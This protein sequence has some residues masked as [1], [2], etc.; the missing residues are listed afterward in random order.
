MID[1]RYIV[2]PVLLADLQAPCQPDTLFITSGDTTYAYTVV[3]D[4][5][6]PSEQY[7]VIGRYTFDPERVAVSMD[8]KRGK[9]SGVYRAWYPNGSPLI[10]AVYGWGTLHGDWTEYDEFGRVAVKGQYRDGLREGTWAFRSEDIV[11]HYD[12]GLKHGKWKYYQNGQLIRIEK[13]HQGEPIRG[14]RYIFP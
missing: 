7:K 14:G 3:Y 13:Y 5:V 4:P 9:P 10:F 6:E 8:H 1:P 12:K 11:G 2:L